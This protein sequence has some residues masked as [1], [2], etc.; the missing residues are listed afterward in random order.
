MIYVI[1]YIYVINN[2]YY[3]IVLFII[4]M[5]QQRGGVSA[6]KWALKIAD[7]ERTG[8]YDIIYNK[9]IDITF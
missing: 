8:R 6:K 7:S 3:Y 5:F 9:Y 1:I 4:L 2:Y